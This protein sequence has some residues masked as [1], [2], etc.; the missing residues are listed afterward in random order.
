MRTA[1]LSLLI[2]LNVSLFA[3][4]D[5]KTISSK[6]D[7]IKL[8]FDGAQVNRSSTFQAE[9]G[10]NRY[11]IKGLSA[12]VDINSIQAKC[13]NSTILGVEYRLNYLDTEKNTEEI[14]I[15][16]EKREEINRQVQ[17]QGG[18]ADVYQKEEAMI[19]QN[20]SIGGEQTGVKITELI[21]AADFFRLRLTEIRQKRNDLLLKIKALQKEMN[22]VDNQLSQVQ[23]KKENINGEIVLTISSKTARQLELNLSYFT[24]NANWKATYDLRMNDV[25]QPLVLVRKADIMQNTGENWDKVKLILSTG[26]PSFNHTKPTLYPWYLS[27][28]APYVPKPQQQA[29]IELGGSGALKGKIMDKA[30][31]EPIPFANVI[32]EDG[33]SQV[34]VT[35]SDFDGFFTIKPVRPGRYDAKATF[36]GYKNSLIQGLVIMPGQITFCD[37]NLEATTV[38]LETFM[39]T[40]YKVPLIDKDKSWSGTTISSDELSKMPGG[41]SSGGGGGGGSGNYEPRLIEKKTRTEKINVQDLSGLGSELKKIDQSSFEYP[42]EEPQTMVSNGKTSTVII[43]EKSMPALY[44][45]QCV[46]KLDKTAFLTARIVSWEDYNLISGDIN[47][48]FEGTF[49]GKSFLDVNTTSDT[50]DLSLGRDPNVVIERKKVKDKSSIQLFGGN[51]KIERNWEIS[52]RNNK[53]TAINLVVEDQYPLSNNSEIKIEL[54]ESGKSVVDETKAS[55]TWKFRLEPAET[56]KL[57]FSYQIKAPTGIALWIE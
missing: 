12:F 31:G 9:A 56:K 47:L 48:Y 22:A 15:L 44:E 30:T 13:P 14:R 33:G 25:A 45:Y 5:T 34:G 54:T 1:I 10:S 39:V 36:M 6:I 49:L 18:I 26:T 2:I 4:S 8:F 16:L 20:Q 52:I 43:E 28:Q 32:I 7:Q 11:L 53:R 42:I 23:S 35:S 51:R 40:D 29:N 19:L 41:S 57:N 21:A 17:V 37:F 27:S 50:L 3:Q 55:L 24:T 46:P 38:D